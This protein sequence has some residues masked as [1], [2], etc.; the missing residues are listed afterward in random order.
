MEIV[1][2][3]KRAGSNMRESIAEKHR[4]KA[5]RKS[6]AEKGGWQVTLMSRLMVFGTICNA[7]A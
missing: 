2:E 5:S 7:F 4:G 1:L 6:I 3:V